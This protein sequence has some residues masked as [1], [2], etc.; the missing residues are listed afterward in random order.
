M[1][2]NLDYMNA[3][4][5][6][7]I[8][9]LKSRKTLKNMGYTVISANIVDENNGYTWKIHTASIL[10]KRPNSEKTFNLTFINY[11]KRV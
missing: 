6:T 8:E 5:D 7:Y 10:Y 2:M 1:K 4:I 11:E 3:F 9:Y